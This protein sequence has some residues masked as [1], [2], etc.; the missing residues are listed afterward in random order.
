MYALILNRRK[1]L[2]IYLRK[3]MENKDTEILTKKV[4]SVEQ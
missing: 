1:T 3:Y 2:I 4:D